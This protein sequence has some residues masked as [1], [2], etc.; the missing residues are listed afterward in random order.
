M[1]KEK[2]I[3]DSVDLVN[4]SGT[5]TILEQMMYCICKIK[6]SKV[7]GTGFFCKIPFGKN[8]TRKFL[9]TNY[10]VID[11]EYF[12]NN[13]K[14]NLLINDEN[15]AKTIDLKIK[16]NTYFNEQY[17]V[18][19]I[20]LNDNDDIRNFLELD[21]KLFKDNSEIIYQNKSL[22]VLQYP[23]GE[24]AS[25]SYGLLTSIDKAEIKH[26]CSTEK[27]SSGSPILNLKTNK[28]IGMHKEG[29]TVFN[30][31]IGTF[32]KY[33]LN[34]FI[35]NNIN[36]NNDNNINIYMNN[37]MPN[38]NIQNDLCYNPIYLNNI[39]FGNIGVNNYYPFKYNNIYYNFN[40]N[41]KD[42]IYEDRNKPGE[43]INVVFEVSVVGKKN[44][45]IFNKNTSVNEILICYLNTIK[46]P[47][48]IGQEN[49]PKFLYNGKELNFGDQTPIFNHA[50]ILV[51]IPNIS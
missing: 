50:K 30:F 48:L 16:R 2:K 24:E 38:Y 19:L 20:E 5:K 28:V 44:N 42:N 36:E 8:D 39:N 40:D 12:K 51:L 11:K 17:D 37:I 10:H 3:K 4:I 32:L 41:Y 6:I 27:G 9:M 13:K 21:D 7:N 45:L 1:E 15:I 22:Y 46:I 43:K 49:I 23:H 47:E 14:L 34:D 26:K 25:V 29:S 33:P 35:N 18:T 31:N